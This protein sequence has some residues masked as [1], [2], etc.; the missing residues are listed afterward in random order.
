MVDTLQVVKSPREP[1]FNLQNLNF[2]ALINEKSEEYL[3]T[4]KS[5]DHFLSRLCTKYTFTHKSSDLRGSV[6]LW[7]NIPLKSRIEMGK[8]VQESEAISV[9]IEKTIGEEHF[10]LPAGVEIVDGRI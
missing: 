4:S 3:I 10:Q 6:W 7:K 2:T 8:N 9:D 5:S 1:K